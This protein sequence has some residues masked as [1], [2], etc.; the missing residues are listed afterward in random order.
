MIPLRSIPKPVSP[1]EHVAVLVGVFLA[2]ALLIPARMVIGPLGAFGTPAAIVGCIALGVWGVS[3]MHPSAGAAF[4]PQPI[5][6][7]L[8]VYAGA[9]IAS[10]VAAVSGVLPADALRGADRSL[11][12]LAAMSGV[13]LLLV[14]GLHTVRGVI[15]VLQVLVACTAVAAA[16]GLAEYFLGFNAGRYYAQIPGLR[17]TGDLAL[18]G[19]RSALPRVAGTATHPIEFGVVCALVLPI[20]LHLARR[21][22]RNVLPWIAVAT[23][24]SALPTSISRSA[25]LALIIGCGVYVAVWPMRQ[26]LLAVACLPLVL[27]PGRALMPGILGTILKLF[28]NF[29]SDPSVAARTVDYATVGAVVASHP[30][31][32]VGYGTYF[33]PRAPILDNQYLG[34]LAETG[35]LGLVA[36]IGLCVV[37]LGAARGVR[38]RSVDPEIRDCAQALFACVAAA[39]VTFATFDFFAFALGTA[40]F[41]VVL[42]CIGALWRLSGGSAAWSGGRQHIASV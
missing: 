42:G 34:Q 17:A 8:W 27:V 40:V 20:A 38:R 33:P 7:A 41:F 26:R 24:A 1:R 9:A 30:V 36:L 18:I 16:I 19:A 10:Y 29:G 28:L 4:G 11:L 15:R 35:V 6:V 13:A 25:I 31:V 2:C 12:Q 37:A 32:G 23:I 22:P 21:N 39:V 14:D 5:R 3:R